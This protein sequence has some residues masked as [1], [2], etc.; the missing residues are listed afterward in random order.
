MDVLRDAFDRTGEAWKWIGQYA[1]IIDGF[2]EALVIECL[3]D[4]DP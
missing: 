1:G 4:R 3:L 2:V